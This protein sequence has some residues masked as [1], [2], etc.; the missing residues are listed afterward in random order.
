VISKIKVSIIIPLYNGSLLI[1][2]CLESVFSQDKDLLLEIIIID[3]GSTDNSVEIVRKFDNQI[4]IVQQSNQGPASARN[5]GIEIA[6][7]KYLAFLDADD[8][9]KTDFLFETVLFMEQHLDIVAVSVGQEHKILGR[10]GQIIPEFLSQSFD[11][12]LQSIVLNNFFGYWAMFNHI[13]TGSVLMKTDIANQTGGQR[14]ELRITEDL[15]FWAYLATFGKW[16]FIPKVLF[17][18]DGGSITNDI[19]WV[20]KMRPRWENVPTVEEW[21]KR[22]ILRISEDE[23]EDYKKAR[24][25]IARILSYNQ[26]ISGKIELSKSQ[27]LNYSQYFPKDKIAFFLKFAAKNKFLWSLIT[28]FFIYRESHR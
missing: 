4:Q 15:E 27:V 18:S 1:K 28:S 26:L 21:Q 14:V 13:C 11:E 8:Y 24:G 9:W 23:L 12:N 10:K 17:V 20:T 5:K 16:G 22:I 25:R 3:D 2:R 7:G 6:T 19:G